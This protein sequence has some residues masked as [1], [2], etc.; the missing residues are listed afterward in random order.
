MNKRRDNFDKSPNNIFDGTVLMYY[1]V[2]AYGCFTK[3][4]RVLASFA[5]KNLT[6][7]SE[8]I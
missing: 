6:V 8:G 2:Q 1:F 7:V 5:A 3:V 4:T